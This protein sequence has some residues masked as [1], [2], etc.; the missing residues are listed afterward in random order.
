MRD[1]LF[2]ARRH[3]AALTAELPDDTTLTERRKVLRAGG[4]RFHGG[5]FWGRR[6]YGRACREY[7][8]R[9][10]QAPRRIAAAPTFAPDIIFPWRNA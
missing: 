2:H 7:L 4:N 1:W 9:H 5:T 8:E 3:V 6:Q 10:G